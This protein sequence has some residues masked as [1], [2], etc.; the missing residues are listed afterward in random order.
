MIGQIQKQI[1]TQTELPDY[2]TRGL[3]RF[4]LRKPVGNLPQADVA[5]GEG[6]DATYSR[7]TTERI[8]TRLA[9]A[10]RASRYILE[11][12][13]DWDEEGSPRF[14]E[15]TWKRATNFVRQIALSYRQS[16]GIWIDPPRIL[17]GPKGSIDIHWKTSKRELL[18]NVPENDTV[19]ADYY[20]SGSATDIIKGKLETSTKNEWILAWLTR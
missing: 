6:M 5:G 13:D 17:P 16:A 11:L 10:I 9:D 15:A 4:S 8:S 2:L 1:L 20:G 19:P 3:A 18:I 12:E 7:P 14:N